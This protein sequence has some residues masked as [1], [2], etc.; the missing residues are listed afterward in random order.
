MVGFL[1][2]TRPGKHTKSYG[3]WPFLMVN[4][5]ENH[6]KMVIYMERSTMLLMG[7]STSSMAI[8]NSKPLN[9]Q[10]VESING[11][12]KRNLTMVFVG[13]I[14]LILL[15]FVGD[16]SLILLVFVGDISLILLVFVG[17]ISLILLVF[18]GD[19]S[20]ILL[21]Y[22]WYIFNSIGL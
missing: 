9:Y 1:V 3:T 8:F 12:Q 15:V 19:I 18:V 22:R 11:H 17:D 13:D 4:P 20:L 5:W 16:I 2:D 7:K 21:V 6:G 10:R 14:S